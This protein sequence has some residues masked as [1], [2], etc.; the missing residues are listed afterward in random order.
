[1]FFVFAQRKVFNH[2]KTYT[3]GCYYT[4]L[5]YKCTAERARERRE[6]PIFSTATSPPANGRGGSLVA[7]HILPW[8]AFDVREELAAIAFLLAEDAEV[9]L[10]EVEVGAGR[11]LV[12]HQAHEVLGYDRY[13][14]I[15]HKKQGQI[16]SEM[17]R[18]I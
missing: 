4:E 15:K 12:A 1:V 7:L 6:G 2:I 11:Q 14:W 3:K 13:T 8:D 5:L 17:A 10:G 16:L 9:V 18:E